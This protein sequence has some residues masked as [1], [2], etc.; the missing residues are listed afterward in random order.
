MAPSHESVS[1]DHR[2]IDGAN[3]ARFMTDMV[4]LLSN[5]ALLMVRL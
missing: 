2:Y 1:F 3:A 4:G 5:P